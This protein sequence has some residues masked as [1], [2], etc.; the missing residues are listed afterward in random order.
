M[1]EQC[2]NCQAETGRAGHGEDSLYAGDFGPYC[3]DCWDEL[4]EDLAADVKRLT[5]ALDEADMAI[6]SLS[7]YAD[8]AWRGEVDAGARELRRQVDCKFA[9]YWKARPAKEKEGDT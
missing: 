7:N 8:R 3:E 1:K 6:A 5:A 4:R 9:D 2:T